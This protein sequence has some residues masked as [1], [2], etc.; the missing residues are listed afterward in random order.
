[1]TKQRRSLNELLG[2][3][4]PKAKRPPGNTRGPLP[5]SGAGGRP[6]NPHRDALYKAQARVAELKA[7]QLAG[8]LVSAAD[9]E[10]QWTE[11]IVDCRQRLLAVASRVGAKC[12]LTREQI[13]GID[14]EIRATLTALAASG[15]V[16]DAGD[17]R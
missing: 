9:V 16:S 5:G 15:G 17:P 6:A 13:A 12:G 7:D 11:R 8:R 10:R 14:A 2:D 4:Q 3:E 1:M